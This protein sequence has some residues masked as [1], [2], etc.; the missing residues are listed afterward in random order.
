[1][2]RDR[3]ELAPDTDPELTTHLLTSPSSTGISLPT[4][5]FRGC[6]GTGSSTRPRSYVAITRATRRLTIPGDLPPVLRRI[7]G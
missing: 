1:M 2:L 4:A 3:G 5:P 7:P 6:S